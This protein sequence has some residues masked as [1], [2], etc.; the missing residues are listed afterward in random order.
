V[1]SRWSPEPLDSLCSSCFD[2]RSSTT[3]DLCFGQLS[4]GPTNS[5]ISRSSRSADLRCVR[6]FDMEQTTCT[7]VI[8]EHSITNVS[9]QTEDVPVSSVTVADFVNTDRRCCDWY[10]ERGAKYKTPTY[11]H[12]NLLNLYFSTPL[13]YSIRPSTVDWLIEQCLTSPPTQYRFSG[14][15]FYRSKDPKTVSKYWR[16]KRYKSKENPEK[17]N[18]TKY[19]KTINTHMEKNTEN[20]L[21]YNNTMVWLGDGS[22]RGQGRQ[23]WTAV[24]LPHPRPR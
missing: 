22:H 6:A 10:S 9:L 5:D 23:A 7:S 14:R 4:D 11:L 20:P 12:T 21:V 24:G 18:N 1:V 2:K 15:Q 17:A 3:A 19:S 16:K 8:D 13:D